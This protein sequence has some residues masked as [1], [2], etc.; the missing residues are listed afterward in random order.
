MTAAEGGGLPT[1]LRL[2]VGKGVFNGC[3][4]GSVLGLN[5]FSFKFRGQKGK[6]CSDKKLRMFLGVVIPCGRTAPINSIH[7][8][9]AMHVLCRDYLL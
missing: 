9:I 6:C 3:S 1:S 8:E 7:H 2:Q 4:E 5:T